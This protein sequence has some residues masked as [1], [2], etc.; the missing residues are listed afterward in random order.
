MSALDSV[1]T[2]PLLPRNLG[3]SLECPLLPLLISPCVSQ[4][5]S[6]GAVPLLSTSAA[7]VSRGSLSLS[8]ATQMFTPPNCRGEAHTYLRSGC[9]IIVLAHIE[10]PQPKDSRDKKQTARNTFCLKMEAALEILLFEQELSTCESFSNSLCFL[11]TSSCPVSRK[12]C[13]SLV[14]HVA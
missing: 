10:P 9:H 8:C 1:V 2:D 6:S 14:F 7:G 13:V 12:S 4:T 11:M 3:L 5:P